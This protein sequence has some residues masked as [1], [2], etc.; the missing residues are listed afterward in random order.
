MDEIEKVKSALC[1]VSNDNGYGHGVLVDPFHLLTAWHVVQG[2]KNLTVTTQQG[3]TTTYLKNGDHYRDTA[4]DLALIELEDAV[5]DSC[6]RVLTPHS[7][8]ADSNGYVVSRVQEKVEIIPAEMDFQRVVFRKK[9]VITDH[10]NSIM[11]I[12]GSRIAA[13]N[14]HAKLEDGQSGS[15]LVNDEGRIISLAIA[16]PEQGDKNIFLAPSPIHFAQFMQ[17][18]LAHTKADPDPA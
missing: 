17:K 6:T 12:D 18:A 3:K 10:H 16:S 4:L 1:V 13:F 11:C 15:P 9:I 2:K 5:F 14:F 8:R 7:L